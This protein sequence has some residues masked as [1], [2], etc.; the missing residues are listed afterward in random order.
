MTKTLSGILLCLVLAPAANANLDIHLSGGALGGSV[1]IELIGDAGET[2]LIFV[3][4]DPNNLI[5]WSDITI[6]TPGF[7]SA[8]NGSGLA[9]ATLPLPGAKVLDGFQLYFQA[10]TVTGPPYVVDDSSPVCQLKLGESNGI[11]TSNAALTSA[12]TNA[13]IAEL[14]DGRVLIAGGGGGPI[15][16]PVSVTSADIYDPCT[17]SVTASAGTM[18]NERA[19]HTLTPLQN[20]QYLVAGGS[21]SALAINTSADIYDPVTDTFTP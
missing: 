11:V 18:S 9:S 13:A 8:L 17:D 21:D 7:I 1:Q 4:D 19:F 10:V 15:F 3:S 5:K 16:S 6:N 12:R 2:Y 20:G 14:P